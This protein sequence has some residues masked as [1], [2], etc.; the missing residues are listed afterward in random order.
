MSI[1]GSDAACN[2]SNESTGSRDNA[3]EVSAN[4]E[5]SKASRDYEFRMPGNSDVD[6]RATVTRPRR[7]NISTYVS[8]YF[9]KEVYL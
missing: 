2:T 1:I 7:G 3:T 5:V 8:T 4:E 6:I 9:P